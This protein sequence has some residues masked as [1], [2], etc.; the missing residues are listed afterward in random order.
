MGAC[1]WVGGQDTRRLGGVDCG[2]GEGV[3]GRKWWWGAGVPAHQTPTW[4]W[5]V[6]VRNTICNEATCRHTMAHTHSHLTPSL[7]PEPLLS[8]H[9]KEAP[10]THIQPPPSSPTPLLLCPTQQAHPHSHPAPH[11]PHHHPP[12]PSPRRKQR[13]RPAPACARGPRRRPPPPL[14][15]RPRH[16][17]AA[18]AH[19]SRKQ[20][21]GGL[22][23]PGAAV[24]VLVCCW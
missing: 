6:Q 21:A 24:S 8:A 4:Q 2:C 5:Y 14:H 19:N 11:P 10:T 15:H 13:R 16:P 17:A 12:P 20:G 3:A 22:I 23:R 1:K 9:T 7:S 18:Q